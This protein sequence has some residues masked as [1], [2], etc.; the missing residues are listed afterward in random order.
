M[1]LPLNISGLDLTVRTIGPFQSSGGSSY[2]FGKDGTTGTT[3][4]ALKTTNPTTTSF[5]SIATKTGFTTAILALAA[6]QNGDVIHFI[7]QDGSNTS[8]NFKYQTF[9]MSTDTF[10]TAE[11][12]TAAINI[13]DSVNSA[14]G[15]CEI[16]FR[17]SDT[18]PT[19]LYPGPRVSLHAKVNTKHR[20]GVATWSAAV[21]VDPAAA[22]TDYYPI[23]IALGASSTIHFWFSDG[24]P[25]IYERAITSAN[26]LQTTIHDAGG[27]VSAFCNGKGNSLVSGGTTKVCFAGFNDTTSRPNN[28]YFDSA[29]VPTLNAGAD[30]DT[31]VASPGGKIYVDG[32]NFWQLFTL[33]STADVYVAK[34]TDFGATWAADTNVQVATAT[35]SGP[36]GDEFFSFPG[37]GI[38]SFTRGG[39]TVLAY[40][41]NNGGTLQYNEVSLSAGP[42]AVSITEA[43]SA[44]DSSSATAAYAAAI[45]E[46]ASAGDSSTVIAAFVASISEAASAADLATAAAAFVAAIAEAASATDASTAGRGSPVSIAEAANAMDTESAI[47]SFVTFVIDAATATDVMSAIVSFVASVTEPASATEAQTAGVSTAAAISEAA[48]ATDSE[49]S[50]ILRVVAIVEAVTAVE[51]ESATFNAAAAIAEAANA[52]DVETA[53]VAAVASITEAASAAEASTAGVS[54]GVVIAEAASAADSSTATKASS[55]S[56]AEAANATDTSTA[57]ANFIAAMNEIAA[58]ADTVVGSK[59]TTA[60]I[61]EAA[62]AADIETA[63]VGPTPPSG[64][65]GYMMG[66]LFDIDIP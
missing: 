30:I 38:T 45:A 61:T 24:N 32:A 40:C 19:V 42:I 25:S 51:T 3:L 66:F 44:A 50:Q 6:H 12:I 65:T 37:C 8:A 22:S 49:D 34:S 63:T 18:Q 43:A 27:V 28:M 41:V 60:A 11:T 9:D 53:I 46:A 54:T 39:N 35:A 55:A 47:A 64:P 48:S 36:N 52:T 16:V 17:P 4:Q 21:V 56:I 58:A 2:E 23:G 33:T 1:A 62:S 57:T 26:A 7:I 31:L 29:N 10:V 5:S 59:A 14:Y 13:T 15:L 20:T